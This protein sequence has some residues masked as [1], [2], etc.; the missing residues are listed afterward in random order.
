MAEVLQCQLEG[1]VQ[2]NVIILGRVKLPEL[3]QSHV[4]FRA[5]PTPGAVVP[6][7]LTLFQRGYGNCAPLA[8]A[9]AA[10]LRMQRIA[11]TIKIYWR[12]EREPLPFHVEVRLPNG[13]VED[14]S[15]RL[16]MVGARFE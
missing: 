3:Y 7:I 8:C 13:S 4:A 10:Q 12:P 5:E 16:G 2:G 14:P 9:R 11:A 6:D 1:V 15:R